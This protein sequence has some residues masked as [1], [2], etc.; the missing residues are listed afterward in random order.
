MVPGGLALLRPMLQSHRFPAGIRRRFAAG[1][2]EIAGN[3]RRRPTLR[4]H[5]I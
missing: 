5:F 2:F 1:F 3:S 4:F